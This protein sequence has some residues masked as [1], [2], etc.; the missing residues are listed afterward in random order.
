MV[1][2]G[3]G[4]WQ[5]MYDTLSVATYDGMTSHLHDAAGADHMICRTAVPTA[6]PG[7]GFEPGPGGMVACKPGFYK[8]SAGNYKCSRCPAG[9][10]SKAGAVA[11]S[12]LPAPSS[13]YNI[14]CQ[15]ASCHGPAAK[16]MAACSLYNGRLEALTA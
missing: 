5:R 1:G 11:C 10:T 2:A 9:T 15:C 7:P 3:E 16:L 6:L 13:A 12:A 8:R 14:T 4:C